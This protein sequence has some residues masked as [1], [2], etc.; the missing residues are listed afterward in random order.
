MTFN[1]VLALWIKDQG[2]AI[3]V[4]ALFR[5]SVLVK[6]RALIPCPE[7][8]GFLSLTDGSVTLLF[9]VGLNL[10]VCSDLNKKKFNQSNFYSCILSTSILKYL[11]NEGTI[12]LKDKQ[13]R[14]KHILSTPSK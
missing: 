9:S 14:K 1:T 12:I 3:S 8:L 2:M 10:F 4:I 13:D 6:T 7:P 11:S 5:G